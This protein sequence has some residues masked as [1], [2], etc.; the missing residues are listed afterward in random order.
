M[1]TFNP[2]S[3]PHMGGVWE[4][5][6]RSVKEVMSGLLQM[7][8]LTDSQLYTLLT[9]VESILN[10]RPLTPIS[11][12]INDYEALTPNHI[13]LGIHKNWGRMVDVSSDDITSRKHWRQ[14]QALSIIFWERWLK[15]YRPELTKRGK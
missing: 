5:L 4:R 1:W 10:N 12:D 11:S 14:V 9:E 13:I 3:A 7:K 2:P 6:V 15:E 8:I